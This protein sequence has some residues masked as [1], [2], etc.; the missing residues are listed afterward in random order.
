MV[1]ALLMIGLAQL[2]PVLLLPLFYRFKPL[3]RPA[4]VS[5]LMALANRA[6]TPVVGVYEWALSAHTK[7]ANAALAGMG[8]TR[9]ILRR[10]HA[11]RRLLRGRDRGRPGA[12]AVA[13]R[14]PRSVARHGA[15]GGAARCRFPGGA[16]GADGPRRR[17]AA[18][19]RWTTRPACRSC[20]WRAG[21]RRSCSCRSSTRCRDRTSGAPTATRSTRPRRPEA[22]ISAM[23]RLS[24]QNLAEDHPSPLVQWLFYSHPPIRAADR[25]RAAWTAAPAR[26]KIEG[27]V[28]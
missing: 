21:R 18:S 25:R 5:R 12:R 9:R 28:A 1:F 13:P 4:L 20:C 23:K 16:R 2:A 10:R 3:D 11:A 15:A 17:R 27:E 6:R 8:R 26:R 19:R 7:K 14:A 24:Q 22:F